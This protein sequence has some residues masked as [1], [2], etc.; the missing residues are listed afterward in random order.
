MLG[1]PIAGNA[2]VYSTRVRPTG[3]N[4]QIDVDCR[5]DVL[6]TFRSGLPVLDVLPHLGNWVSNAI[7]FWASGFDGPKARRLW[8]LPR[9]GWIEDVPVRMKTMIVKRDPGGTWTQL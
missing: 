1:R 2:A 3:P 5:V 8:G 7:A 9:G 6:V 4:P